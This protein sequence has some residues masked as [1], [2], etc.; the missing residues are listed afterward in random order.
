MAE[1]TAVDLLAFAKVRYGEAVLRTRMR[2]T[3]GDPVAADAELTKIS[4]SVVGRIR[5]AAQSSVGWPVLVTANVL[6]RALEL[7]NW[8]TLAGYE[9]VSSTQRDIGRAAEKFFDDL[10]EGEEAW[11]VAGS[12]DTSSPHPLAARDRDGNALL[13]S[14]SD[15]RNLFGE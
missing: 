8:R 7:F 1:F 4:E 13:G 14:V 11:G 2:G 12:T 10:A 5:S 15:R 6:Q 9:Q 3:A